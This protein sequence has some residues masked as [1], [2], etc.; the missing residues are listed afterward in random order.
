MKLSQYFLPV[1]K[2]TPAN[3]ECVS[4]Q[5]MLR[6]GLIR[7]VASGIYSWLPF[8]LRV[9]TKVTNMVREEMN[10]AGAQELLLPSVQPAELWKNSQ[11]WDKYGSELMRFQDRHEREFCYGP[12]HEEVITDIMCKDLR[13]YRQLPLNVY[14]IQTKFRDEIRPRFGVMRS[15]EFIM[16]DAY[17]FHMDQG[18]LAETYETMYAT[19]SRIFTRL[20]L[21]FRAVIADSGSIGGDVSH[22]FQVLAESGEDVIAYS[23]SSDYAANIEQAQALAPETVIANAIAAKEKFATPEAKTIKDLFTQHNIPAEQTIKTLIV[24]GAKEPMVALI[25]RGDHT[26]NAVKSQ[27]HPLVQ[28]PLV[29]VAEPDVKAALGVGFGSLGP[30]GISIPCIVDTSAAA[31][32]AFCCGANEPAHHYKN[33]SWGRDLQCDNVVDLRNVEAGDL[34]PDGQGSL[35]LARGIEVGHIF[36][37]GTK[38]SD[39]MDLKVLNQE[40]QAVTPLMGCYGIGVTR[41]VAAAIEQNHDDRGI[42]WPQAMAPFTVALL[43]LQMHKSYRVQEVAL[44]IYGDLMA[45]GIEVIMDDRRERPGVMFASMDLLGIPHRIVVGERG[46]DEHCIEYKAR[47]SDEVQMWPLDE[48]VSRITEILNER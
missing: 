44:K 5:L 22:E 11:R 28:S 36:Q 41:I 34:S 46:I 26:L 33:V 27:S 32:P 1:I 29:M 20:G 9:L 25:L 45:A 31:L 42:I 10:R 3:A 38:Y 37:L 47:E 40:G 17:S 19:Y 48:V 39:V 23:D 18:S 13:S 14:Q 2:E 24:K 8:G 21:E 15:R 43:P 4:H 6:A 12:T 7:G 30:V 35:L 16:K